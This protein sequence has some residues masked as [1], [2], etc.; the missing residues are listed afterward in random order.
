MDC[1]ICFDNAA[2]QRLRPCGCLNAAFCGDCARRLSTC[3]VCRTRVTALDGPRAPPMLLPAWRNDPDDYRVLR[4]KQ[5]C[6]RFQIIARPAA[7]PRWLLTRDEWSMAPDESRRIAP[8]CCGNPNCGIELEASPF[9]AEIDEERDAALALSKDTWAKANGPPLTTL[10]KLRGVACTNPLCGAAD[11]RARYDCAVLAAAR[12][13]DDA[14]VARYLRMPHGAPER[15]TVD[16]LEGV[17]KA[18]TEGGH[19][20]VIALALCDER[21]R[22]YCKERLRISLDDYEILEAVA[23]L[24][25]DHGPR[26]LDL[27]LPR[28]DPNTRK[29]RTIQDVYGELCEKHELGEL[30]LPPLWPRSICDCDDSRCDSCRAGYYP[31]GST[32]LYYALA[33]GSTWLFDRLLADPRVDPSR[34]KN[35]LLVA[36]Q[37]GDLARVRALIKRGAVRYNVMAATTHDPRDPRRSFADEC[38]LSYCSS[39]VTGAYGRAG[40]RGDASYYRGWFMG[41]PR[42]P[43]NVVVP[44]DELHELCRFAIEECA[45]DVGREFWRR[46]YRSLLVVDYRLLDETLSYREVEMVF[47]HASG[48]YACARAIRSARAWDLFGSWVALRALLERSASGAPR[49]L[50]EAVCGHHGHLFESVLSYLPLPVATSPG[51]DVRLWKCPPQLLA[52]LHALPTPDGG[53]A[54]IDMNVQSRRFSRHW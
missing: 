3:P 53:V 19:V 38:A 5:P 15:C 18:G 17:L 31:T 36:A 34:T 2:D 25:D 29:R 49:P 32:P 43:E 20:G 12:R 50:A 28:V 33:S 42:S 22:L 7:V 45:W 13:G 16:L 54:C 10:C 30:E 41:Y 27:V 40:W 21:L 51:E 35:P 47:A 1:V 26:V 11:A 24:G 23:K 14:A 44:S 6:P 37:T 52:C 9:E 8:A 4:R 48:I 39:A 46:R